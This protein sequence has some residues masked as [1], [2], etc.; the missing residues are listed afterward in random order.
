[1]LRLAA[2]ALLAP[3]AL[4]ALPPGNLIVAY[5]GNDACDSGRANYAAEKGANVLIWFSIFLKSVNG[6]PEVVNSPPFDCVAKIKAELEAEGLPTFHSICIGGWDAPH[7]NTTWSGAEWFDIFDAWNVEAGGGERLFDGIDWDLEGNDN[8]NSTYAK[9]PLETLHLMGEMSVAAKKAG[10][11]VSLAPAQ[12][13]MDVTTTEFGYG[14]N[15]YPSQP[16]HQDDFPYAGRNNYCYLITIYGG[17]VFDFVS[18]QLYESYAPANYA[19]TQEGEDIASY[20]TD[21]AAALYKGYDVDYGH[22]VVTATL[23]LN[24]NLKP[25][26]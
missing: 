24:P 13:Y 4:A 2:L 7:P 17:V 23:A 8:P 18:V 16:W 22:P 19:V 11:V 3:V 26:P 6:A 15:Y 9:L 20:L 14:L 12:S 1:M 21:W 10:Y 5:A 25:Y